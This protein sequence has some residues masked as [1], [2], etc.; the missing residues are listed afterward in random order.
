LIH[1]C[2]K[3]EERLID[4]VFD[5]LGE[6]Q[7]RQTL[8]EV[9]S[10]EHCRAEYQ[11]LARTLSAVDQAST[12][13]TP[14]ETYWQAYEAKLRAKLAADQR[15]MAL[16]TWRQRWREALAVL[17][18]RPAWAMSV[19][20]LLGL[21][22]FLWAMLAQNGYEPKAPLQAN[23]PPAKVQPDDSDKA[24]EKGPATALKDGGEKPPEVRPLPNPQPKKPLPGDSNHT[25]ARR[26]GRPAKRPEELDKAI[27]S[28]TPQVATTFEP[29]SG[30]GALLDNET[31]R[32]FEKAQ[33]FLRAFRNLDAA[34][35]PDT[36]EIA[37]DKQ[38]SRALLFKNV[39]LRREAEAKG[40][41]P[42]GQVLSDLEPLLLDI[43]NLSDK[44]AP[45]EIRAIH[46]RLQKREMIATLQ[47]Y[48]ARPVIAR[49]ASD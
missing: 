43:A 32:H 12:A 47:V 46:K 27:Q 42:V 22:L 38:R 2:Q 9:E 7:R 29:A 49:A 8:A 44:A 28:Q 23:E 40:N 36:F 41:L 1:D 34:G 4:L 13:M 39:L 20:L 19:A 3:I 26:T 30:G 31:L 33:M 16:S 14:D 48:A 21:A 10:C 15:P 45:Y 35:S 11:S 25:V 18:T 24:V 17:T 37:N 5:E 6:D